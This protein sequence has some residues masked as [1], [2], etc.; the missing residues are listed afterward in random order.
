[1]RRNDQP[2]QMYVFQS[3][4]QTNI[5][6]LCGIVVVLHVKYF[7]VLYKSLNLPAQGRLLN[8]LLDFIFLKE[9]L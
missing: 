1:M 6:R 9:L 5:V 7:T 4:K 2:Q 8:K 3:R